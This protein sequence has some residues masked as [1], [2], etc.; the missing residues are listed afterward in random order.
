M[1]VVPSLIVVGCLV[2]CAFAC[3]DLG[4]WPIQ[5]VAI[6]SAREDAPATGI[7]FEEVAKR[8]GVAVPFHNG[9]RGRFDLPEIMGGGLAFHDLDGDGLVDLYVLDGGS[10]AAMAEDPSVPDRDETPC[11]M[12]R[13][14]GDGTFEEVTAEAGAPGPSYAMGVA[15]GDVDGDGRAD[16]FV[17]GWRDQRL[18]LNRGGLRFEDVTEKAGLV[19]DHWGSSA[20]LADLDG[21]GDLDLVVACY[22]DYDPREVPYCVAPDGRR[23]YCGPTDFRAQFD[24]LYRNEGDGTFNDVTE[25]SGLD[26]Y[27]GPGLGVVVADCVGDRRPDLYFAHDGM[28]CRLLENRGS[29]RFV[30]HGLEAGV[31]VDADGQMLSGMGIGAGDVDGDGLLELAVTNFLRR[32]TVLFRQVRRGAFLDAS[33]PT[34]LR[35]TTAK[36]LGFGVALVDFDGDGHRDLIQANGHVL[37]RERLGEPWAMPTTVLAGDGQRL[38]DVTRSAGPWLSRPILGRGLAVGDLDGDAR[39]DVAVRA[40]DAPMALLRN[41]SPIGRPLAIRLRG[42]PPAAAMPVGARVEIVT[43]QR[44]RYDQLVAGGSY[45]SASDGTIYAGLRSDE[46]LL[47]VRVD[48]PS[49]RSEVW[50]AEELPA[51]PTITFQEGEGRALRRPDNGRSRSR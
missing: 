17:T 5:A 33:G 46:R 39:P 44:T 12:F 51:S 36:V 1:N 20:A 34:R 24:R 32:G 2:V 43:D 11:R 25:G 21:D 50:S 38:V 35:V 8:S 7:R 18:Y 42:R 10:I 19:A 41:V 16:L 30:E 28:A 4:L 29:L 40:I 37:S 13:N 14:R 22:V 27:L 6:G 26:L 49:G 47:E 3:F 15:V 48:W 31:A 45:L 9:S 23:D